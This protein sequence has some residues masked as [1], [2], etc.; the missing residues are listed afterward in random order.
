MEEI[1]F[2]NLIDSCYQLSQMCIKRKNLISI[3]IDKLV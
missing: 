1:F 3:Y 2:H